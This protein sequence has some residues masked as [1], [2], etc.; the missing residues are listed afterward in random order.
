MAKAPKGEHK[1]KQEKNQAAKTEGDKPTLTPREKRLWSRVERTKKVH[2]SKGTPKATSLKSKGE[3]PSAKYPK[4][5]PPIST[6][7]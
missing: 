7:K 1:K 6:G 4:T 5:V 2:V 3:E